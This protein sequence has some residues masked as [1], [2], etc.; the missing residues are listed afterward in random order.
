MDKNFVGKRDRRGEA[1]FDG[2]ND[3]QSGGGRSGE[4]SKGAR[5]GDLGP[6]G[7]YRA[8]LNG[9]HCLVSDDRRRPVLNNLGRSPVNRF[10]WRPRRGSRT[11]GSRNRI[12][13]RLLR[14]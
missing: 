2:V 11:G 4:R 8:A 3:N 12:R 10:R 1:D 5:A 7:R 14:G 6:T 13:L 9:R